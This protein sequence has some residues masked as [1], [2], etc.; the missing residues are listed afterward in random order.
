MSDFVFLHISDA[1]F[2]SVS[3]D[4]YQFDK[5]TSSLINT[6]R[7]EYRGEQSIDLI[8]FTGD[9]GDKGKD[10]KKASL[11]FDE[12]LSAT[13]L[14]ERLKSDAKRRLFV[15][16]GNHD[17]D[18]DRTKFLDRTLKSRNEAD[19]FFDPSKKQNRTKHF[20]RFS[21]F[22]R[23]HNAYFK[24]IR[25]YSAEDYWLSEKLSMTIDGRT[26]TIAVVGF[27]SAWFSQDDE[28]NAKL[29]IGE[30]T[31]RTAYSNLIN[32]DLPDV[33]FTLHHHPFDWL[34][35]LEREQVKGLISRHSDFDLFGHIHDSV[36]EEVVSQYGTV[37][38]FQAGAL[39]DDEKRVK[40]AFIGSVNLESRKVRMRPI[41]YVDNIHDVWTI[42]TSIYPDRADYQ[43]EFTLPTRAGEPVDDN[44]LVVAPTIEL[45]PQI[46]EAYFERLRSKLARERVDS[47]INLNLAVPKDI[48]A[49]PANLRTRYD[50]SKTYTIFELADS[51]P[52][53]RVALVGEPGAGKTTLLIE[54]VKEHIDNRKLLPVFIRMGLHLPGH[55]FIELFDLKEISL[56]E[57]NDLLLQ[58]RF[59]I[60]FDGV[61]ECPCDNLDEVF[62]D[63][64]RFM[65][66]FP[67]NQYFLSCRTS[68]F[69]D[70][71]HEDLTEVTVLPVSM[72]EV[73]RRF[74]FALGK[75][76][77]R[78]VLD[79]ISLE[80]G[81]IRLKEL[82]QNPLLLAMMLSLYEGATG[83]ELGVI[84]SRA[85]IYEKFLQR[86]DLRERRKRKPSAAERVW[87]SG[88]KQ[89]VLSLVGYKMQQ[90]E[91]VF[92]TEETL[93]KWIADAVTSGEWDSW[94][95]P[96]ARPE[97]QVIF[98]NAVSHPPIKG[99]LQDNDEP[100]FYAFLHQSFGEY[101]A[102][103]RL[104]YLIENNRG[105]IR[106]LEPFVLD[107]TRR[108]WEV[109]TLLCGLLEN[110]DPVMSFIKR[111][112]AEL[113]N[114]GLL[115][116][117]GRCIR[118]ASHVSMQDA[119]DVRI[120]MIDA[121][122]FWDIPFD[123][124]L[125][126][127][128]KES[129]G[130]KSPLL[131]QRLVDDAFRFTEKYAQVLPVELRETSI[132]ALK[133][134]L[135]EADS[136]L[137]IDAAYTLGRRKYDS[138]KEKL[139]AVTALLERLQS[140]SGFVR[141]QII[142][143]L[144]ELAHPNALEPLLS[145]ISDVTES[146]HARAF[147]LNGLGKIGDL[148]A[149]DPIISYLRNHNNPYRDSASW[150]LQMLGKVAMKKDPELFCRIK[151]AYFKALLTETN[152]EEGK[153]AKGNIVYSLSVLNAVEYRDDIVNW[154]KSESDPYVI[155]DGINAV[156]LLGGSNAAEVILPYL[157]SDDP[158]IRMK[159]AESLGRLR[160]YEAKPA[161]ENLLT[162]SFSI[163]RDTAEQTLQV[164]EMAKSDFVV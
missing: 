41:S 62:H 111:R 136:G 55:S 164:L 36:T 27:N 149:A 151:N 116:L 8:F 120:R 130:R 128:I 129:L 45:T 56:R 142:I 60:V 99:I 34:H 105:D 39:Y 122:K 86:L 89:E 95:M 21:A 19:M 25:K 46:L 90:R 117:A 127:A 9:L 159:A 83:D 11:F 54:L 15:V 68:E 4:S 29:W 24:D 3:K 157:K 67:G 66:Q 97:V 146:R 154:L 158:V 104:K 94:W 50:S 82:C 145:I 57:L 108:Q 52:D 85:R 140:G 124:D 161:L 119:D 87:T 63:L 61:N 35:P 160:F 107:E 38:R 33:I 110:A 58:G 139:G 48:P 134:Y 106:Q 53:K 121:F 156:G 148:S 72:E 71:V 74:V 7:K 91:L 18:R 88:L 64:L 70:W 100:R 37:L 6:L 153:Y 112:A 138:N 31:C 126:R 14:T 125:I 69:P 78:E 109:V 84:S 152:D 16:P 1:H 114:Q 40:R 80:H 141:E 123:Y 49:V 23:F 79:N 73:E 113:K 13:G 65:K 44:A 30:R 59:L 98:R 118:D 96:N 22:A 132:E 101:Y 10:Y 51:F 75:S 135:S 162:D 102:A 20:E 115:V 133:S 17:V 92:V 93:Q 163:V 47:F 137:I 147:A 144:K 42:D 26:R 77:G 5:V 32:G 155:E 43:R 2:P 28:D 12:L 76:K 103:L 81:Y 143:A 150:S 131:P